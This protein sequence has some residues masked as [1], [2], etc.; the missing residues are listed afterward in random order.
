MFSKNTA[1][2]LIVGL[3]NPG[4]R[5]A[6]TRHNL[7]Q[8]VVQRLVAR[9]GGS[10]KSHRTRAFVAQGCLG[11]KPGGL[12]GAK[13][14]LAVGQCFMN[15]SGG[16]VKSLVQFYGVNPESNLLL[17]HDDID[18]PQFSLRLKQGGGEGGHNGLRSISK[19]LGT[20]NYARLR[21]GAGRPDNPH[22]SPADYVLAE[23]AKPDLQSWD[24]P[25]EHAC[26]AVEQLVNQGLLTTQQR[27]H[28][29]A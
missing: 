1:S 22:I 3:G 5:Y 9:I 21:L 28:S 23:M 7:G 18:L 2:W 10:L 17:I 6:R 24:L 14:V 4:E 12:P 8:M 16:P 13:V 27:L 11:L 25:L 26:D 20:K 15:E 29:P 19:A